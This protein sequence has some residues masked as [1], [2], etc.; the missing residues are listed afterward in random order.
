ML[1]ADGRKLRTMRLT[2]YT[3][4]QVRTL[5][6]TADDLRR[7]WAASAER[8]AIVDALEERG[9][10]L[11]Y[12]AAVM[13]QDDADPFDLLCHLAFEGPVRT[14]RA[15]ADRVRGEQRAFFARYAPDARAILDAMLDQ[16]AEYGPT[17]LVMPEL[18][19]LPRFVARGSPGE[20]ARLFGGPDRL[21]DAFAELQA[22]LYAA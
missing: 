20:I 2:D 8:A 18:L 11:P 10:T 1:D 17:E 19:H 9:I 5:T 7:R 4:E 6:R 14:R 16:Y 12:L 3:G 13:G 21:R 15:R 22:L